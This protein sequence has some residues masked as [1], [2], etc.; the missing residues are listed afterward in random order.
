ETEHP[1]KPSWEALL[2]RYTDERGRCFVPVSAVAALTGLEK[3]QRLTLK[4]SV[5][6]ENTAAQVGVY[7]VPSPRTILRPYRWDEIVVLVRATEEPVESAERYYLAAA[8]MLEMGTAMA[9]A[10][11]NVEKVEMLHVSDVINRMFRF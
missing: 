6:L 5:T 9:A 3:R 7:L 10:D 1:D 2:S 11:G 4:Q 8:L